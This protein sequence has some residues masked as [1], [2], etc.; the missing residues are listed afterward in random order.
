M[1]GVRV[2]SR[3]TKDRVVEWIRLAPPPYRTKLAI[4]A[5]RRPVRFLLNRVQFF[6]LRFLLR[7]FLD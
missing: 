1:R 3:I 5:H 7:V 2:W 6:V 4:V